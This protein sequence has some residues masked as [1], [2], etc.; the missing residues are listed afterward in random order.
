MD[1]GGLHGRRPARPAALR[2]VGLAVAPANAHAWVRERAHWRT[3]AQRR[4][5]RGARAVR[6][7]AARAGPGRRASLAARRMHPMD[8]AMSWRTVLTMVLLVAARSSAAGRC[9]AMQRGSRARA[10]GGGRSDYVLRDFELIA[11]DND[12]KE[13]FT[14]RAPRTAAQPRRQD[15]DDRHAAVP[16]AR[17]RRRRTGRC[18]RRP[19][20]S[21]TTATNCAC[22]ATCRATSPPERRSADHDRTPSS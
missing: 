22:A 6:P 9:G 16:A 12:G 7:A 2:A 10:A 13:S 4:R 17:P 19:A 20:G 18:V 15:H 1:A 5:G 21:A 8:A 3:A 11:L 14:L